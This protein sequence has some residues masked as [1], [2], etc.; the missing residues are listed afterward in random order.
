VL[1]AEC[2]RIGRDPTTIR[3]SQEA[4]LAIARDQAGLDEARA[5]AERRFPGPGW[6]LHEGGYL[7]TPPA[8]VDTIGARLAL[9]ITSFVFFTH[10]RA[11]EP[12]L[13]LLAEEVLPHFR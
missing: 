3:S 11:A 1:V 13:R 6:G 2:E 4:V 8:I 10:D 12:T 9:G 5:K 7:G